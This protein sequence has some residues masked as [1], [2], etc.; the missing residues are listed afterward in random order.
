[1]SA[2]LNL[3]WY[4]LFASDVELRSVMAKQLG[5][6]RAHPLRNGRG[7]FVSAVPSATVSVPMPRDVQGAQH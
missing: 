2:R 1:M 3:I 4:A 6:R 5:K 7:E